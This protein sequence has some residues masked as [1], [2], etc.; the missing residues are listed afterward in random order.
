MYRLSLCATEAR[1][2]YFY[3]KDNILNKLMVIMVVRVCN[4]VLYR[5]SLSSGSFMIQNNISVLWQPSE[6]LLDC[7]RVPCNSS[8]G[9]VVSF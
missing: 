1:Q 7:Q 3:F 6:R 9:E 8:S 5:E 2:I 4:E